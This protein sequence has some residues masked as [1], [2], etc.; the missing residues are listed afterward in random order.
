MTTLIDDVEAFNEN[1]ATENKIALNA[2]NGKTVSDFV[3]TI[4][5]AE[6]YLVL[7]AVRT[8]PDVITKDD[9]AAV[10]A[11]RDA[12][13]ALTDK[14]QGEIED[15][16]VPALEKAEASLE[17]LEVVTPAD[18]KA[19]LQDAVIK[20]SSTVKNG[21]V[22]VTANADVQY[23]ID[24]GFTVEFKFYKSTKKSSGYKATVTKNAAESKTYTNTKP[25]KGA[26]YYKYIIIVTDAEGN[27]VTKTAL[28]ECA[29]AKR[30]IK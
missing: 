23:L 16:V 21:K 3:V 4:R 13:E 6:E 11:V 15:V 18:A 22:T 10:K 1:A 19:F 5:G 26:N 2:G 24:N 20:A 27:V 8:L 25:A 12:F 7:K 28:K 14:Q 30:T 29:Y 17:A 9:A